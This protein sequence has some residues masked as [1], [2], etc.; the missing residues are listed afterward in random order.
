MLASLAVFLPLAGF[1]VAFLFGRFIGDRGAQVITCAG[2]IVAAACSVRLFLDVGIGGAD[3]YTISLMPWIV[4]GDFVVDWALRVD[5]LSATMMCVVTIVS[6]CVH[7]YSVGYMSKDPSQA[8][9]MAYL[10]LFTFAMMML[11]TADNLFQLFFGWE[12]VGVASYLLIGFWNYKDSANAAAI[13]AFIV[14]RVGDVGLALGIFTCFVLFGSVQFDEIFAKASEMAG[15]KFEFLGFGFDAL[16]VA[17]LLLFVG[18][19]GKSAQL[20]LHTWLPDA[21]EG[22]TPVSALIHAATMV[23]AG[24]F[25]ICRMS[26]MFEYA[27][28]ALMVVTYVGAATAIFAATIGMTQFDIKRVIA[29]STMSQLG[30]MFFAAGVGAYGAAMFHLM[31]HAFFKALLFLCAGSVIHAMSNEQDM[32]QMG[33][34][35]KKVPIT[36]GLML[37]GSL[38][39]AGIPFFA[40]FYSKDMILETAFAANT[41]AGYT[42]FWIGLGAA[43]LTAFYSWRLIILTFDGKPRASDEV[44][45]HVHETPA[46]MLVPLV[47]LAVGAVL[48]GYVFYPYFVGDM[49][50]AFWSGSIYTIDGVRDIL[51]KAHYVP[52]W[53]PLAPVAAG[54]MGIVLGYVAYKFVPQLPGM[55]SRLFSPLYNLFYNR[56]YVDP[57]YNRL[58]VSPSWVLGRM[59]FKGGDMA[60][61]NGLGPDGVAGASRYWGGMLSRLQSGYVYHYAFLMI[62]CVVLLVA[63]LFAKLK[64]FI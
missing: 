29:Y 60:T 50:M 6:A 47:V 11:V 57:L 4:S 18:A 33:G 5:A 22:P 3:A 38:A 21:M 13:K 20:G 8:R 52:E 35:A 19:C 16:T 30:Y 10:S 63:W 15:Q 40:G 54:V 34:I 31:T 45:S 27:P 2:L 25:L 17:C 14:N 37:I 12:G 55:M 24:V 9:F 42:A 48:A 32:R 23:T 39:L 44:M 28:M 36:Y 51:Y 56:W 61:I 7:V 43:L 46:V 59:L 53:V 26:P 62:A 49:R 64:G 1:L 58:F 41:T